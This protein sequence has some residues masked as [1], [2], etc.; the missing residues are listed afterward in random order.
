MNKLMLFLMTLF[1]VSGCLSDKDK[2]DNLPEI[3]QGISYSEKINPPKWLQGSWVIQGTPTSGFIILPNDLCLV[4]LGQECFQ[5]RIDTAYQKDPSVVKVE[6]EYKDGYYRLSI[7]LA[8]NI[9]EFSFTQ[10]DMFQAK[11]TM[12]S[13]KGTLY[14]NH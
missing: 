7:N 14:K 6:Q 1:I 8:G 3:E 10:R 2:I 9:T 11:Y 5:Y 4:S 12:G 13:V